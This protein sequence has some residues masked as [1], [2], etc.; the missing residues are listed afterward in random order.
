MN[1]HLLANMIH[2]LLLIL[3]SDDENTND[4]TSLKGSDDELDVDSSI[5]E[6]SITVCGAYGAIMEFKRGCWLPFTTIAM[7]LNLLN[8][9]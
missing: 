6:P 4:L 9:L 8:L 3:M 1:Y 7:L 2:H 5:F